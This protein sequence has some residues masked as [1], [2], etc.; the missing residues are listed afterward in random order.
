M[1][2]G[3]GRSGCQSS[4]LR[5]RMSTFNGTIWV[6]FI[7]LG[8]DV[9]YSGTHWSATGMAITAVARAPR[10]TKMA[11]HFILANVVISAVYGIV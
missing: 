7:F 11:A 9:L 8:Q 10:V 5:D 1:G 2:R 3:N 6:C 4:C